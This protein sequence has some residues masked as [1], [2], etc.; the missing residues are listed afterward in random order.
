[1]SEIKIRIKITSANYI[2]KHFE[3][4]CNLRCVCEIQKIGFVK[5]MNSVNVAIWANAH[6]LTVLLTCK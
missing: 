4:K 6:V 1:M 2:N 5:C 3:L